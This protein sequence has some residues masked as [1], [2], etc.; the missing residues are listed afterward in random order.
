MMNNY[1]A[2]FL[3]CKDCAF[4]YLNKRRHTKKEL[5]DKLVK[6]EYDISIAREVADYLE[7][8]KYIDDA[9]YARR[10]IHD[11]VNIKKH[12]MARIKR[13]LLQKGVDGV[14]V[15]AVAADLRPDTKS[16]LAGLVESKAANMDLSDEKQL[17]RLNGFLLR[18]GFGYSDI[19]EAV[20]EYRSK[21]E[22][23]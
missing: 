23:F 22:N 16:V 6:R 17:N 5:I 21:K 14:V 11:A 13:D 3:E 12:G 1:N 10:F 8:A 4:Y 15:D 20:S 19:R 7:E 18:R 9:D 2:D